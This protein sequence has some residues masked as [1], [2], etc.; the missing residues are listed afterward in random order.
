MQVSLVPHEG[1]KPG[2]QLFEMKRQAVNQ[3]ELSQ[4]AQEESVNQKYTRVCVCA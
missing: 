2:E 4:L 3:R 1:L